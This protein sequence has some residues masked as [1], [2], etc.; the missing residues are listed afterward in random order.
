MLVS[1]VHYYSYGAWLVPPAEA[2]APA[3]SRLSQL[4]ELHL[5]HNEIGDAGCLRLLTALPPLSPLHTLNLS[6]NEIS[7]AAK[8]ADALSR[9]SALTCL[10]L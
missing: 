9:I 6:F 7:P 4:A 2:L 8:E 10:R 5:H 1:R 3:L